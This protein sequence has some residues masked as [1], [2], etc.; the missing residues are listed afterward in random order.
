M[1][2]ELAQY[3]SQVVEVVTWDGRLIVGTLKGFDQN[4][5]LI[6]ANS[7]E[8]V[9]SASSGVE[10]QPLGL[11]VIR[12]DTVAIVGEVDQELEGN[13]DFSAMRAAPI[14]SLY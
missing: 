9:F 12:G 7:E 8:R 2:A 5:N 1:A 13:L 3:V 11:Y 6:L 14:K 4:L 10:R